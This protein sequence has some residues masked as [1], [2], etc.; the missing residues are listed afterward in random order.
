[1]EKTETPPTPAQVKAT[2]EAQRQADE[3][4]VGPTEDFGPTQKDEEITQD[5]LDAMSDEEI[6]KLAKAYDLNPQ[7]TPDVLR[8]EIL[9]IERQRRLFR[10]PGE[11]KSEVAPPVVGVRGRGIS[12]KWA[13]AYR[14]RKKGKQGSKVVFITAGGAVRHGEVV[15][16]DRRGFPVV[17]DP[18]DS[19]RHSIGRSTWIKILPREKRGQKPISPSEYD[20]VT[21]S[22]NTMVR[23]AEGTPEDIISGLDIVKSIEVTSSLDKLGKVLK[24]I[25]PH[26]NVSYIE[27]TG[28]YLIVTPNGR[29]IRIGLVSREELEKGQKDNLAAGDRAQSQNAINL[30]MDSWYNAMTPNIISKIRFKASDGTN[31]DLP[32][33]REQFRDMPYEN[34][35]LAATEMVG[36]GVIRGQYVRPQLKEGQ[37]R[38]LAESIIRLTEGFWTDKTVR[39]EVFHFVFEMLSKSDQKVLTDEFGNEEKANDAY[40]SAR[41]TRQ[42]HPSSSVR[43]VFRKILAMG[44]AMARAL[45]ISVKRTAGQVWEEI[46]LD[47]EFAQEI[48]LRP[49][50]KE[51]MRGRYQESTIRGHVGQLGEEVEEP[52]VGVPPGRIARGRE[53]AIG[54]VS[55][56]GR[57]EIGR[58]SP[59]TEGDP[60]GALPIPADEE[61]TNVLKKQEEG[62]NYTQELA[63]KHND[64]IQELIKAHHV[65]KRPKDKDRSV[66]DLT[67][68]ELKEAVKEALASVKRAGSARNTD[69][70]AMDDLVKLISG[71]MDSALMGVFRGFRVKGLADR[72]Q[73]IGW[74]TGE[75]AA[76]VNARWMVI[77]LAHSPDG[78]MASLRASLRKLKTFK[79][80]QVYFASAF[81]RRVIRNMDSS[82][83][84]STYDKAGII[85]AK[86]DAKAKEGV[87]K[88]IGRKG[89]AVDEEKQKQQMLERSAHVLEALMG[90]RSPEAVDLKVNQFRRIQIAIDWMR[91]GG[92]R[93]DQWSMNVRNMADYLVLLVHGYSWS[94]AAR[95]TGF[96]AIAGDREQLRS[97]TSKARKSL[98]EYLDVVDEEYGHNNALDILEE[99][100]EE[101]R[102]EEENAKGL[103]RIAWGR[104]KDELIFATNLVQELRDLLNEQKNVK[105]TERVGDRRVTGRSYSWAKKSRKHLIGQLERFKDLD[106]AEKALLAYRKWLKKAH[107]RKFLRLEQEAARQPGR[108]IARGSAYPTLVIKIRR[109][110]AAVEKAKEALRPKSASERSHFM[111]DEVRKLVAKAEIAEKGEKA[112]R[113]AR[114]VVA[115]NTVRNQIR[116]AAWLPKL[117]KKIGEVKAALDRADKRLREEEGKLSNADRNR[118][119]LERED[120]GTRLQGFYD[121]RNDLATALLESGKELAEERLPALYKEIGRVKAALDK[122]DKRL[123]EEE[124]KLSNVD[125]AYRTSLQKDLAAEKENAGE[126]RKRLLA[127]FN[128]LV[129]DL[130]KNFD[131]IFVPLGIGEVLQDEHQ[132]ELDKYE[133]AHKAWEWGLR[134]RIEEI[135]ETEE[136]R[137]IRLEATGGLTPPWDKP[138]EPEPWDLHQLT[139]EE[140]KERLIAWGYPRGDL[141]KATTAKA[142][143]YAEAEKDAETEKKAKADADAAFAAKIEDPWHKAGLSR[144]RKGKAMPSYTILSS[145]VRARSRVTYYSGEF[146]KA[147]LSEDEKTALWGKKNAIKKAEDRRNEIALE[148]GRPILTGAPP[149]T[150]AKLK[151]LR[152]NYRLLEKTIKKLEAEEREQKPSLPIHTLR[153][154]VDSTTFDLKGRTAAG[155]MDS[156]LIRG[157]AIRLKVSAEQL[158][159]MLDDLWSTDEAAIAIWTYVNFDPNYNFYKQ[160]Q[161]E[162]DS[163][164]YRRKYGEGP[165]RDEMEIIGDGLKQV[166][167]NAAVNFG[168]EKKVVRQTIENK[169]DTLALYGYAKADILLAESESPGAINKIWL[170]IK[171]TRQETAPDNDSIKKI[172]AKAEELLKEYAKINN[173]KTRYTEGAFLLDNEEEEPGKVPSSEAPTGKEEAL[174]LLDDAGYIPFQALGIWSNSEKGSQRH[175]DMIEKASSGYVLGEAPSQEIA[176]EL[177]KNWEGA[178]AW[179]SKS[180]G[181]PEEKIKEVAEKHGIET[182]EWSGEA[183]R[184]KTVEA[185]KNVV[186]GKARRLQRQVKR[187]ESGLPQLDTSLRRIHTAEAERLRTVL[188]KTYNRAEDKDAAKEDVKD[189]LA[190]I[191]D[192]YGPD[193]VDKV[194]GGIKDHW[195]KLPEAAAEKTPA[196]TK[197]ETEAEAE[198]IQ[199][200]IV[201]IWE[202]EV[203]PTTPAAGEILKSEVAMD[204]SAPAAGEISKR[205]QQ[206]PPKPKVAM[207]DWTEHY[208]RMPSQ[209][210]TFEEAMAGLRLNKEQKELWKEL[211][212]IL[213]AGTRGMPSFKVGPLEKSIKLPRGPGGRYV[214]NTHRI[215]L[216]SNTLQPSNMARLLLHEAVHAA[217]WDIV[218]LEA[219]ESWG[220]SSVANIRSKRGLM[221]SSVKMKRAHQRLLD[222]LGYMT[223]IEETGIEKATI[224]YDWVDPGGQKRHYGQSD[225]G[226]MIAEAFTNPDFQRF[227]STVKVP[228]SSRY[229]DL[230]GKTLL[231][232]FI[233]IVKELLGISS[234][235]AVT[236][237]EEVLGLSHTIMEEDMWRR[238]ASERHG[239]LLPEVAMDPS[240]PAAVEISK[241]E[242]V[243]GSR[244]R[245]KWDKKEKVVIGEALGLVPHQMIDEEA[246]RLTVGLTPSEFESLNPPG[247]KEQTVEYILGLAEKGVA[248]AP[249]FVTVEWDEEADA[250]QVSGHEGRSRTKAFRQLNGEV[251]MTVDLIL[252]YERRYNL[253]DK[254]KTAPLIPDLLAKRSEIVKPR[255]DPA[256]A[257]EISKPEV[258]V[259]PTTRAGARDLAHLDAVERGHTEEARGLVK[260]AALK[261][262]YVGPWY[263]HGTFSIEEGNFVFD[264]KPF[265]VHFGTRDAAEARPAGKMIDDFIKDLEIF[266]DEKDGLW[267]WSSSGEES[268]DGFMTEDQ[269]RTDANMTVDWRAE[270]EDEFSSTLT[271][272]YLRLGNAFRM[273]DMIGWDPVAIVRDLGNRGVVVKGKPTH[274]NIIRTLKGKP[275]GYDSVIYTNRYEDIGKDSVIVFHPKRIKSALPD[276]RDKVGDIIPL[277]QRFDPTKEDIRF[278]VGMP[279]PAWVNEEAKGSFW[280]DLAKKV[281]K[282]VEGKHVGRANI[283]ERL[284]EI[285]NTEVR[286]GRVSIPRDQLAWFED[287]F[288]QIRS[289]TGSVPEIYQRLGE[290]MAAMIQ[291][292]EARAAKE[293]QV[294]LP[295]WHPVELDLVDL[296]EEDLL[297]P[298]GEATAE[299]GVGRFFQLYIEKPWKLYPDLVETMEELIGSR[300]P[301]YLQAMRDAARVDAIH[302]KRS[303]IAQ[304][305]SV[306]VVPGSSRGI[307]KRFDEYLGKIMTDLFS[308]SEAFNR[309][310]RSTFKALA[311]VSLGL[312]R[313][314][315]KTLAGTSADYRLAYDTYLRVPQ[316]ISRIMEGSREVQEEHEE[317]K[318]KMKK[319]GVKMNRWEEKDRAAK[320]KGV[321]PPPKPTKPV[322]PEAK[323]GIRVFARGLL[324]DNPVNYTRT[325]MRKFLSEGEIKELEDAGLIIPVKAASGEYVYLSPKS[326]RAIMDGVGDKAKWEEFEFYAQGKAEHARYKAVEEDNAAKRKR[327]KEKLE[328]WEKNK[329][330]RK[331]VPEKMI[332]RAWPGQEVFENYE[333]LL[334]T[335][336]K[337]EEDN[338]HF[339]ESFKELEHFL[340]QLLLIQVYSGER[341]AGDVV[342][343]VNKYTDYMPLTRKFRGSLEFTGP[344]RYPATPS[345]AAMGA[346]SAKLSSKDEGST[347]P[348]LSLEAAVRERVAGTITAYYEN[349][350]M[351][352][353]R[354]YAVKLASGTFKDEDTGEIVDIPLDVRTLGHQ[355]MTEVDPVIRIQGRVSPEQMRDELAKAINRNLKKFGLEKPIEAGH[356]EVEGPG[357]ALV[358]ATKP[359]AIRIVAPFDW[360]ADHTPVLRP[361]LDAEGE[362]VTDEGGRPVL[363]EVEMYDR[364]RPMSG[365]RFY[366]IS[367]PILYDA[368][369]FSKSPGKFIAGYENWL[370]PI[371]KAWKRRLTQNF[372][373]GVWNLKRDPFTI[374]ALSEELGISIK[375]KKGET[376]DQYRKRLSNEAAPL[377]IG[378]AHGAA[379]LNKLFGWYPDAAEVGE[380]LSMAMDS[381]MRHR[382]R[383]GVQGFWDGFKE[384]MKEDIWSP[385]YFSLPM[386]ERIS[387]APG[388]IHGAITK[389][390][391]VFLYI[392]FQRAWAVRT[393]KLG[394]QGSYV[395]AKARGAT[396][397]QAQAASDRA[398]G[399]FANR[400]L[401]G[402]AYALYRTA[403]FANPAIQIL[404]QHYAKWRDPDWRN[405]GQ[406]A[407]GRMG[408][409]S[410]YAVIAA[411]VNWHLTP[412]DEKE[413][414]RLR[415]DDERMRY[416]SVFG[417]FRL[418]FDYGI[419]GI[420]ESFTYN[421]TESMLIKSKIP[422]EEFVKKAITGLLDV[423]GHPTAMIHPW[424]K[425]LVLE[426]PGDFSFFYG[427]DYIPPHLKQQWPENPERQYYD[428]TPQLYVEIGRLTGQSPLRIQHII[429]GLFTSQAEELIKGYENLA[430]GKYAS[431]M[432]ELEGPDRIVLGR[433]LQREPRGWRAQPT[434]DIG[435]VR[436]QL[437]AAKRILAI[438][439][440]GSE[441]PEEL[442]EQIDKVQELTKNSR[443]YGMLATNWEQIR[444]LRKMAPSS[445]NEERIRMLERSMAVIAN[446]QT[447]VDAEQ[448]K[449]DGRLTT[450]VDNLAKFG[451]TVFAPRFTKGPTT[452]F[453]QDVDLWDQTL[454]V[455]DRKLGAWAHRRLRLA[456][457]QRPNAD[458]RAAAR[459]MAIKYKNHA[460]GR[461]LKTRRQLDKYLETGQIAAIRTP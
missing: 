287:E 385:G 455:V 238:L 459:K 388:I 371:T 42:E 80:I 278:E 40:L 366:Q 203:V 152:Q 402:N 108:R 99:T 392:T 162:I 378:S 35:L 296:A 263:H 384:M 422:T 59:G 449:K 447:M 112:G 454:S 187:Y 252:K 81:V 442:Q 89:V 417:K 293:G 61:I 294:V 160:Q 157:P 217:T 19:R 71:P 29:R 373:F 310:H 34:Q 333:K 111:S 360:A 178:N 420:I 191:E 242:V 301:N 177:Q 36:H 52:G 154:A 60:N 430:N 315:T 440:D 14:L 198:A 82:P 25:F 43:K 221:A 321:D 453:V 298:S 158:N 91:D 381:N 248:L 11:I 302:R 334:E 351:L 185:V 63:Q 101:P 72:I 106:K 406:Y 220:D 305:R 210:D 83:E 206:K 300:A 126:A 271:E 223:G 69:K 38:V 416:M 456:P 22:I 213:H 311:R 145:S 308:G 262:G 164:A 55:P 415:P 446:E 129:Y 327:Y 170:K 18:S 136:D 421:L 148:L 104:V 133:V 39:H 348:F 124:G 28:E 401:S 438:M 77:N 412:D 183:L 85:A 398:P 16:K 132:E 233:D 49:I 273:S 17:M 393:E 9:G 395:L 86:A 168:K 125:I 256:E 142:Q 350:V 190:T 218:Y 279:V 10:P 211:L 26:L 403:G 390:L 173:I 450:S 458:Q 62:T 74:A 254:Q 354:D 219:A 444:K 261:S 117:Y 103:R 274:H 194:I 265:G 397:E 1:M 292:K 147:E 73:N 66:S 196:K 175:I 193:V 307:L 141:D 291:D 290:A 195:I 23:E 227:L 326:F 13:F 2:E 286:I 394:R 353:V 197:E 27:D 161:E 120:L 389:P 130:G 400:P 272:V 56:V 441:N 122:V 140:K 276:I 115:R 45:G 419:P 84:L 289:R 340:N 94:H 134:P 7:L 331:P 208:G 46:G 107:P 131:A 386:A 312:A 118:L 414:M 230:R 229:A 87:S 316:E 67:D 159:R 407:A 267:Y 266:K 295:W 328:K 225:V 169:K 176:D 144:K 215:E 226:E 180:I 374:L 138:E 24:R 405:V 156:S 345:R 70:E 216:N 427:K 330:G 98:G 212:P 288:Y 355:L 53:E 114:L 428:S 460:W 434:R 277:S 320:A 347:L 47:L 119:Q 343:M 143:A 33:T 153:D 369:K 167:I 313:N 358:K 76:N 92:P 377:L 110:E 268:E 425:T 357:I 457:G 349:S 236:A 281:A 399:H 309:I 121:R 204:P 249:P 171:G 423:P 410:V 96:S 299:H 346:E 128:V 245:G 165:S 15:G 95:L 260:E 324:V 12:S 344:G 303:E 364:R 54:V 237:L 269:A 37:S 199:K 201:E 4:D 88:I 413:K 21:S 231:E 135:A 205:P 409:I 127:I 408:M 179:A 181:L 356:L 443:W 50:S 235:E 404:Y 240:A 352:S 58:P 359:N 448:L 270:N 264:V 435:T 100:E 172:V 189:E 228:E 146:V 209:D 251:P 284:I 426:V 139:A 241:P 250:W 361:K 342:R 335:V 116:Q 431:K 297:A 78:A 368:F 8:D 259:E 192:T 376:G 257:V 44:R 424:L 285:L 372:V 451:I 166:Y 306:S 363:D 6:L 418:P 433:L 275:Y 339:K 109:L 317:Y 387:K 255:P 318:G 452:Y 48:L 5:T 57:F 232:A 163:G 258:G 184:K 155:K 123:G 222:I 383:K 224:E 75:N 336:N 332:P 79:D 90:R 337:L 102:P 97:L 375:K 105:V 151:K 30:Y 188:V 253:T 365:R 149:V 322:Q 200:K 113:E 380:M 247:G 382:R 186:R 202:S 20:R 461:H 362:P 341:T 65:K 282:D 214:P 239:S 338:P 64:V 325:E 304:N 207:G 429:R 319:W 367:D 323:E 234:K 283:A 246:H 32:A 51:V 370:G 244:K 280:K 379:L 329:S 439:M 396:T 150:G 174:E 93:P 432:D 243:W 3:G 445:E 436:R 182:T 411:V 68:A 314:V 31:M 391:D 137:A 437:D 41:K